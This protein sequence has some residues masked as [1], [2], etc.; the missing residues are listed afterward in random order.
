MSTIWKYLRTTLVGGLLFLLP[1]VIIVV[2][3]QKAFQLAMKVLQPLVAALPEELAIGTLAPYITVILA[4]VLVCFVAG[5]VA[6]SATGSRFSHTV[7]NLILGKLPG[8][9][10]IRSMFAG[11]S[12]VDTPVEVAL[13][14]MEGMFVIAFVMERLTN[15]FVTVFIPSAPT[16][17][18]GAVYFARAEQLRVINIGLAEAM[19]FISKLGL[20]AGK[21]L[22]KSL[23][24]PKPVE[25]H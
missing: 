24:L 8:Y 21:A 25:A 17:H 19:H 15:G 5:L 2:V 7:E 16:P 3:A 13:V 6:R 18:A 23:V 4:L 20:G 14:E 22:E 1:A 9:T 10:F 12:P 11:T